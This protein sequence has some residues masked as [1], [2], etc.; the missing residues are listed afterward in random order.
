MNLSRLK[1]HHNW[2][3]LFATLLILI[4]NGLAASGQDIPRT[5]GSTFRDCP[6]CPEMV[7]IPPGGF[8]MGSDPD[9]MSRDLKTMSFLD[10]WLAHRDLAETRPQHSVAIGRTFAMGRYPV[11]RGEFAAFVRE[12]KYST[13]QGCTLY[14]NHSYPYR[15]HA[16]WDAPGFRQTDRDPVVCVNWQDAQAYITWLNNMVRRVGSHSSGGGPYRLPSDAELEYAARAGQQ[17]ARWWGDSI[18]SNNADC[19]GCG[20]IWDNNQTAPVDSFRANQFGLSDVLGNVWQW[21]QDC[22]NTSYAGAPTDGT[23]WLTGSCSSRVMRGGSWASA[24]WVLRSADRSRSQISK[25][26]NDLGFRVARA[27]P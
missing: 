18:G 6:D 5:P 8:L 20:S 26:F 3:K 10:E 19:N 22:W 2:M 25:R 24:P 15:S 16:G 17:T 12:T 13:G 11:T 23:A 7:V 27:L 9:E 4:C 14:I 1:M 21:T